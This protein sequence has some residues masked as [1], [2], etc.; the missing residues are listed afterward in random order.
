MNEQIRAR[1][2]RLI[3][4]EGEQL[5]IVSARDGLR[6]ALEKGLDLVEVA[7]NAKPP[8]CRIMD[9]GKFKYEQSKKEREARKKQ[10]VISVKEVKLRLGIEEHDFKVKARNA[11]RF[12]KEGNKVKITIMFRGREISHSDLGKK[13]CDKIAQDVA[14]TGF[15][16]KVPKVEG[17]NM[18]MILT[19]KQN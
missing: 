7:P 8:V 10:K 3:D 4:A 18:T 17:R 16:E 15:V 12:L 9:H 1:Q 6:I 2:I 5:G 14:E 11:I 19:P 13:L